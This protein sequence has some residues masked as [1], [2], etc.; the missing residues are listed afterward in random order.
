MRL[1]LLL[2]QYW[3]AGAAGSLSGCVG[4]P[5]QLFISVDLVETDTALSLLVGHRFDVLKAIA[6]GHKQANTKELLTWNHAK[7]ALSVHQLPSA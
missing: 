6:A 2:T 4:S 7:P 3:F 1:R 5:D